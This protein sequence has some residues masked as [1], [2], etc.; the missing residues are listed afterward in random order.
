MVALGRGTRLKADKSRPLPSPLCKGRFAQSVRG[1]NTPIKKIMKINLGLF[2][3][4]VAAFIA[5]GMVGATA[6]CAA[7]KAADAAGQAPPPGEG[8]G[9]GP[10]GGPGMRG[11]GWLDDQQREIMRDAYMKHRDEMIKIDEKMRDAHKEL[12]KVMLSEKPDKELLREKAEAVAKIQVEQTMLRAKIF[13][14]VAPTL[15]PEQKEQIENNPFAMQML[16]TGGFGP[17][18]MRPQGGGGGGGFGGQPKR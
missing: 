7:E 16:M 5:T 4:V 6:L 13:E 12:T 2:S 11:A 9:G 8:R 14:A 17:G 1:R 10:G 15:K 3:G 18:G